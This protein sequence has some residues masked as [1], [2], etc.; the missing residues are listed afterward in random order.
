MQILHLHVSIFTLLFIKKNS[1]SVSKPA[2]YWEGTAVVDGEF[3]SLNITD[4]LGE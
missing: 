2:P 4:F 3:K 1:T